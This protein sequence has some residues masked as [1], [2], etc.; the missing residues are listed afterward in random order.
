MRGQRCSPR[1]HRGGVHPTRRRRVKGREIVPVAQKTPVPKG[2][3]AHSP[4]TLTGSTTGTA[5][6]QGRWMHQRMWRN[7]WNWIHL[8]QTRP[9]TAQACLCSLPS[10]R[11]NSVVGVPG[12]LPTC[13]AGSIPSISLEPPNTTDIPQAHLQDVPAIKNC[14]A[15]SQGLCECFFP[16]PQPLCGRW[17]PFCTEPGGRAQERTQLP[18]GCC[19]GVTGGVPEGH[20]AP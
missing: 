1:E 5:T 13:H 11:T 7:Q 14:V 15:N 3:L 9:V 20:H 16:T 19:A 2:P 8:G 4:Q 18:S 12:E 17:H 10:E 6:M